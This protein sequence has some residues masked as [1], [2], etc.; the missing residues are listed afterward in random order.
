MRRIN[1][2]QPPIT[3][4]GVI[5]AI[6]NTT[7]NLPP[8]FGDKIFRLKLQTKKINVVTVMNN[9]ESILNRTLK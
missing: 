9:C 1:F 2:R 3:I 5:F 4:S 6:V 7:C 8:D